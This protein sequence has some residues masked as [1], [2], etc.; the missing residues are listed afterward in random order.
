MNI[1]DALQQSTR[2][3]RI[4]WP[5]DTV[6]E[7]DGLD[8]EDE[9]F[10]FYPRGAYYLPKP[11]EIL[12]TDWVA[13]KE[14]GEPERE[15][16]TYVK[17]CQKEWLREVH[18]CINDEASIYGEDDETPSPQNPQEQLAEQ[19]IE[20]AAKVYRE[21][22]VPMPLDLA[23]A[24]LCDSEMVSRVAMGLTPEEWEKHCTADSSVLFYGNNFACT[25]DG[26]D[27]PPNP[28]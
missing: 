12:A 13:V 8:S 3:R 9:A 15:H 1:Y 2:V 5:A 25:H 27:D 21:I 26:Y 20:Y 16:L 10:F 4:S 24:Y 14:A 6:I 23:S 18:A 22:E 17:I 7:V 11:S 19:F 28:R